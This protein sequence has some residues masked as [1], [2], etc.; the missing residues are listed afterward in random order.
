[1][2]LRIHVVSLR[3]LNE[4]QKDRLRRWGEL[5]YFDAVLADPD[6]LAK[7]RDAEILIITPRVDRDIVPHLHRCRLISVQATGTDAFNLEAATRKGIVVCHVPDFGPHAVAEHAFA[8]LLAVCR[9]L[10]LGR[11]ILREGSWRTGIAYEAKGLYGKTLGIFG[12]GKIGQHL[13]RIG[14]GFSMQVKATTRHPDPDRERRFQ[15]QFVDLPRLLRES[16]YLILAAPLTDETRGILGAKEF[17][18]MKPSAVLVNVA[19]GGLVDEEALAAALQEGQLAGAGVDVFSTEPPPPQHPLLQLDQVVATPHAAAGTQESV[20]LLLE[21]AIDNVE[22][23]L[24]GRPQN[25][26]NRQALESRSG[27]M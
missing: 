23:F 22:A 7:C 2:S 19:R 11:R 17:G 14:H 12:F 18:Q 25:V 9:R 3:P 24:A 15:V 10:E 21:V 8:L 4:A 6:L 27:K 26:V 13:S 16:D 20:Q 1:M 5:V